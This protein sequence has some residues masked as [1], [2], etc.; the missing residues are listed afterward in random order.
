MWTDPISFIHH[1]PAYLGSVC[2]AAIVSNAAMST[3]LQISLF[4]SLLSILLGTAPEMEL[5][6]H[7]VIPGVTFAGTVTMFCIVAASS[8]SLTNHP[9]FACLSTRSLHECGMSLGVH[10]PPDFSNMFLSL[11][12]SP[13]RCWPPGC[14]FHQAIL[15]AFDD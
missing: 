14:H 2:L 8:Y 11:C 12:W 13:S 4:K 1:L 15:Q 9:L 3:G 6:E 10:S 5:S 7:V